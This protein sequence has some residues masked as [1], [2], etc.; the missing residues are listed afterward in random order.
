MVDL[1]SVLFP[2]RGRPRHVRELVESATRTSAT[3][4]VEFVCYVDLDDEVSVANLRDL[5]GE[6]HPVRT[7]I[8]PHMTMSNMWNPLAE[9][10][11]GQLLMFADDEAVFHTPGW[12]AA[13]TAEFERWP[14]RAVLVYGDDRCHGEV[15]AAYFFVH[16]VWLKIFGRLTPRQFTYGYAD[17]WC[18]EV[19]RAA[20]RTAYLP[21]VVIENTAPLNQPPDA[22]HLANQALAVRDRPGDLYNAT[23]SEREAD[24]A[25][26]RAWV[27]DVAA[28]RER[29]R[30]EED[31]VRGPVN[32]W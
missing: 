7:L 16:R 12:D 5:A 23:Q 27:D 1:I 29:E 10:A 18:F 14:D 22:V 17:V 31:A 13:V 32:P 6:G 21:D 9:A 25:R 26:L 3:G 19:A 11:V 30:L 4:D 20:G 8:G 28:R 24:V 15:L 2:T